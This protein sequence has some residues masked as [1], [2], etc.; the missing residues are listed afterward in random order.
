[1]QNG[2]N[3]KQRPPVPPYLPY[4]T[5]RTFI[6]SLRQGMPN[7]IDRSLM[8]T[9]SGTAQSNL[10]ATLRY[11]DLIH[12]HGAPTDKLIRLANSE[13]GEWQRA[14]RDALT[15]AYPFLF[16]DGF[17]LSNAT[18]HSFSERFKQVAS[19]DTARKCEA[20]FLAA[21]KD[22][23]LPISRYVT[24]R[25][26]R[27]GGNRQKGRRPRQP[28]GGRLAQ[29]KSD[30]LGEP[31]HEPSQQTVSVEQML[32]AKFPTFDPAWSGEVQAKWFDAFNRLMRTMQA[33]GEPD[34]GLDE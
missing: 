16:Q 21:A 24:A 9:L 14:F 1:M 3:G 17:D 27:N 4:K 18:A 5:F 32:L 7:R 11:L 33:S 25:G 13:G 2:T 29:P 8:A 20:F 6:D 30:G 10:I 23:D 15:G 26:T 19:G 12:E 22:A 34:E 28:N 31:R